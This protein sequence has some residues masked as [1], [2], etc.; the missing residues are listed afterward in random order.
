MKSILSVCIATALALISLHAQAPKPAA[1]AT[2]AAKTV[3]GDPFVNA[4]AGQPAGE[5]A[6]L[7]ANVV[8]V[9]EVYALPKADALAILESER[10]SAARYN[11][12]LELAAAK[13]ARL[14]TLTALTT[15]S[16]NKATTE[17]NDEVR[18]PTE[19][20]P[21]NAKGVAPAATAFEVRNV[22]DAL[23]FEA[24]V[25]PDGRTCELSLVPRRVRLAGFHDVP[26]APGDATVPQP[27]FR[28]QSVTTS[29]S[30]RSGEPHYLGTLT[31]PS[32]H[33]IT[34]GAVAETSLAFLRFHAHGPRPDEI[35]PIPEEKQN[36][37]AINLEYSA[38]SM[39]R[40]Q[41]REILLAMPTL[42][43]PW[44]KLQALIHDKQARF[45]HLIAIQTKSGQRAMI[46][47]IHELIYPT[48]FSPPAR[49]H[50]TETTKRTTD[51]PGH[52][53]K[54]ETTTVTA[55]IASSEI[56]PGV[57]SAFEK[58]N[59]GV[60]V[61]VEPVIGPDG[62]TIDL[63]HAI[64]A[65]AHLGN[66]N[67]GPIATPFPPQPLFESRKVTSAQTVFVGRHML[68]GTFNPP[69]NDGVNERA[70]DGRTWL[71]FVRALPNEP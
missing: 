15:K 1:G 31:P 45:E 46:E 13:K 63:S 55:E 35:K 34:D 49:A 6:M 29:T 66:L 71:L 25:G 19:F 61:E 18:Y 59:V 36:G 10:G 69:D 9:L 33:G 53:T 27:I 37:T 42:E 3:A 62:V 11:R 68:V 17:S 67:P 16:G 56:L 48:E 50:T 38:Y 39:D 60:S 8:I 28:T 7:P 40:A 32:E 41:A 23:E 4:G 54:T 64:S 14:E 5:A 21:G 12:V 22:G 70:D 44:E 57:A 26:G 30:L 51:E 2:P 58:R 20:E 47:E 52:P 24:V 65:I 43:A